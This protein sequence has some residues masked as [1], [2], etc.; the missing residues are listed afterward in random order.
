MHNTTL[1]LLLLLGA[2]AVRHAGANC[3]SCG[4]G[5]CCWGDAGRACQHWRQLHVVTSSNKEPASEHTQ[6]SAD[7]A[8]Q[9]ADGQQPSLSV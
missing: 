6:T 3:C 5:S 4:C 1:L 8:T 9:V 7:T 2:A